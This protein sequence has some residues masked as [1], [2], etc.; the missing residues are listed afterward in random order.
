[1]PEIGARR[2][3]DLDDENG[4]PRI[5]IVRDVIVIPSPGHRANE[6]D[7]LENPPVE[8]AVDLGNGVFIERLEQELVEQVMDASTAR[9]LNFEAVRQFGQLYS[10]WREVPADEYE[11]RLFAW[12]PT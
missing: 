10:F 11:A 1:M 5:E 6:Q 3:E 4:F 8:S 7:W 2:P 12:D 9:G